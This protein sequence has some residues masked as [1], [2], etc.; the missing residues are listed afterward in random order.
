MLKK[1]SFIIF[2]KL[3]IFIINGSQTLSVLWF[4][5]LFAHAVGGLGF[6]KPYNGL[7]RVRNAILQVRKPSGRVGFEAMR[8]T[9][10]LMVAGSEPCAGKNN[11]AKHSQKIFLL[12]VSLSFNPTTSTGFPRRGSA[13]DWSGA[14]PHARGTLLLYS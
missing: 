9:T 3:Y 8:N 4:A 5:S 13:G 12:I 11:F 10:E 1:Y 14:R 6:Q 7:Q 2:L